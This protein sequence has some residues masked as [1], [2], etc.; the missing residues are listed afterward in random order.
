MK[1]EDE[2]V[3]AVV[4]TQ[5]VYTNAGSTDKFGAELAAHYQLTPQLSLGGSYTY[6]D[7]TYDSLTEVISSYNF[8]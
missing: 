4:N 6:S 7:F 1:V 2:I 3:Q 8:V 5:T